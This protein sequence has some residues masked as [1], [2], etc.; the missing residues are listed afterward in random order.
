MEPSSIPYDII[1]IIAEYL[2]INDIILKIFPIRPALK[3]NNYFWKNRQYEIDRKIE[4]QKMSYKYIRY[5]ENFKDYMN[6]LNHLG[7]FP[8][9]SEETI[10]RR[11]CLRKGILNSEPFEVIKYFIN[12]CLQ[13][14]DIDWLYT[15]IC[16]CKFAPLF[17]PIV[18]Y[19]VK[20]YP[21]ESYNY[22]KKTQN[23]NILMI[24]RTMHPLPKI[25]IEQAIRDDDIGS[26]FIHCYRDGG[27]DIIRYAS[28]YERANIV[29]VYTKHVTKTLS[30]KEFLDIFTYSS[31][32][33]FY[34]ICSEYVFTAWQFIHYLEIIMDEEAPSAREELCSM[35][36][37]KVPPEL[38]DKIYSYI[39]CFI[40]CDE[41]IFLRNHIKQPI[42][43]D[44]LEMRISC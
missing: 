38:H 37:D 12:A 28:K 24:W 41:A 15:E 11:I 21:N 35:S 10:D 14:Y 17:T 39:R 30:C 20:L 36:R 23:I 22:L 6:C 42:L 44:F 32:D 13:S 34:D 27:K 31:L 4:K 19:L 1:T 43:K 9:T 8:P 33:F 40:S 2:D 16:Y 7:T 5:I 18:S 3:D 26:V 29:T 25:D